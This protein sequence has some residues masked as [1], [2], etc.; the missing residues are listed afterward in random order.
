MLIDSGEATNG[1]TVYKYMRENGVKDIDYV[2]ATPPHSDHIGGIP[3][4]VKEMEVGA[5]ILPEIPEE[6]MPTSRVY[7]NLLDIIDQKTDP[8]LSKPSEFM[9]AEFR[10]VYDFSN[11]GSAVQGSTSGTSRGKF[12]I[13]SP[14]PDLDPGDNMNNYSVVILLEYGD[15]KFLFT[16]DAE[17][18]AETA[19]LSDYNLPEID[20]LKVSHHGSN[21]SSSANFLKELSPEIAVI[22]VGED[23]TYGHPSDTTINA[24]SE[25]TT[26]IYRTD[27]DGTI[28][29]TTDGQSTLRVD[30]EQ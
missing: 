23:N 15:R 21:T 16:G 14:S 2:V 4:A 9:Y 17:K 13:I 7:G 5:F 30:N 29:L 22:G 28:V 12:T 11:N 18:K 1:G 20:V 26:E 25:Y 10:D 6:Y 19:I 8:Y 27:I 3:N 24:L